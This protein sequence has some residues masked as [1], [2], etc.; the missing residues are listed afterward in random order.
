[1][2]RC[3]RPEPMDTR[4]IERQ[5]ILNARHRE[6]GSALDGELWNRMALPW[7]YRTDPH[8]EVIATR[9]RAAL[10]DVSALNI[11]HVRGADAQDVLDRLVCID[12]ARLMPGSARLGAEVDEEG[13]LTDDIMLMRDSPDAFRV[14]HGSGGAPAGLVAASW[15]ALELTRVEAALLFYPFDMPEG[16]TTPWELNMHWAV[17]LD[18]TADYIGKK[19][20]LRLRGRERFRQA[21]LAVEHTDAVP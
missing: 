9:T 1:M 8:E 17:D 2:L 12:V 16:D 6:L 18:K 15:S 10:Y 4:T 21:G 19:A 13:A 14:S 5:S 3:S 20:V 11:I 7:R